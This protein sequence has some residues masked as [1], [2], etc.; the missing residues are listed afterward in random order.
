MNLVS[1]WRTFKGNFL[2]ELAFFVILLLYALFG[3]T[4]NLKQLDY[5]MCAS[6]VYYYLL[7]FRNE[8]KHK[9]KSYYIND[10]T[11]FKFKL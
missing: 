11:K 4:Y 1:S 9:I 6:W 8:F 10:N 5:F 3:L 2:A 7:S